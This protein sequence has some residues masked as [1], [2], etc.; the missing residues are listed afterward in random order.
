MVSLWNGWNQSGMVLRWPSSERDVMALLL[1]DGADFGGSRLKVSTFERQ[2]SEDEIFSHIA[3]LI[4][5]GEELDLT[6]ESTINQSPARSQQSPQR[7]AWKAWGQ[8]RAVSEDGTERGKG[9]KPL[10]PFKDPASRERSSWHGKSG[11]GKGG[12]KG[13]VWH[14]PQTEWYDDPYGEW[15]QPTWMQG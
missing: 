13:G 10:Y 8:V 6:R 15:D 2:M 1:L 14:A 12:P 11:R 3:R 5:E 7:P 9:V 4:R